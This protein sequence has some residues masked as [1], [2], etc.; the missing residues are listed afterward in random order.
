MKIA[1]IQVSG[2]E[3][4]EQAAI[5][6]AKKT[7]VQVS[8]W[9]P[10]GSKVEEKGI[11]E[12]LSSKEEQATQWNVRDSHATLVIDPY[13]RSKSASLA[14]EIAESFNRSYIISDEYEDILYWLDAQEEEITLNIVGPTEEEEEG[15]TKKVEDL[16]V[17]V[18]SYYNAIVLEV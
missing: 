2:K 15:I 12:T 3:G 10:K 17:D 13:E 14:Y 6:A 18:F 11:F 1:K 5:E 4:A 8:G 9:K 16:L 7:C